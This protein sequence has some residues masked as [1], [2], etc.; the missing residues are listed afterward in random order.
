[1][2]PGEIVCY[3]IPRSPGGT[4]LASLSPSAALLE[5]APARVCQFR[6]GGIQRV[7]RSRKTWKEAAECEPVLISEDSPA[8]ATSPRNACIDG[9][10]SC[11]VYVGILG[12]R[13]GSLAPSSKTIVEEEYDEARRK[14]QPTLIFVQEGVER[15]D[16]QEEFIA[17]VSGYVT[18][19]Y[20]RTF[21]TPAELA[22]EIERA[23]RGLNV[24]NLERPEEASVAVQQRVSENLLLPSNGP[25]AALSIM[26]VR[27]EELVDPRDLE[28]TPN[29]ILR[30]G[31][32]TAPALL[33]YST[34]YRTEV[35]GDRVRVIANPA[36][37][38]EGLGIA[39]V[40]LS[41]S[42]LLHV[43]ASIA[44]IIAPEDVTGL[45]GTVLH[46]EDLE[47]Q[48]HRIFFFADALFDEIDPNERH[49]AFLY[50]V[51]LRNIGYRRLIRAFQ[52]R[53]SVTMG[54]GVQE[55]VIAHETPRRIARPILS[56]PDDEIGRVVARFRQ[57][58]NR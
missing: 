4:S 34:A 33:D 19:N 11:D 37:F 51:A 47:S 36:G 5:Y 41:E 42:G 55:P 21:N 10:R 3:L 15:E 40:E 43:E 8:L 1:M 28:S 44:H 22:S 57:K 31:H 9:V 53:G 45:A 50:N 54:M 58:V 24:E 16:R 25:A 32:S 56:N 27:G 17:M 23:L 6:R 46:E 39:A 48:L 20:R 35:Q 14:G 7:S 18:G 13:A 26:S 38:R 29:T 12:E 2:K 49:H 52:P 30:L